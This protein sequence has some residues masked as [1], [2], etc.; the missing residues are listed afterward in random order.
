MRDLHS[1]EKSG[2]VELAMIMKSG[3]CPY[4]VE[5]YGC[6]IRDVCVCVCRGEGGGVRVRGRG[7]YASFM[8]YCECDKLN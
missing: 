6:L 5:F 2:I 8:F 1:T 7:A 3:V 4:I